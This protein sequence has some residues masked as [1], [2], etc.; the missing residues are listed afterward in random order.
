MSS[1]L[2]SIASPLSRSVCLYVRVYMIKSNKW[3]R[4]FSYF[5]DTVAATATATTFGCISC[6][7]TFVLSVL[8]PLNSTCNKIGVLKTVKRV[9]AVCTNK[10]SATTRQQQ[11]NKAHMHIHSHTCAYIWVAFECD[12]V[13]GV[14]PIEGK[15]KILQSILRK[16]KSMWST[17]YDKI[18]WWARF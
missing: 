5:V 4:W 7:R 11:T 18:A 1:K 17:T 9:S 13:C 14:C 12:H 2:Y 15:P 16:S 8:N 6:N 3:S 10:G